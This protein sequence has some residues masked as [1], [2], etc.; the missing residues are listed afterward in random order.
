VL[1]ESDDDVVFA[2]RGSLNDDE[3]Y[4]LVVS[5]GGTP[6]R[7]WWD[8]IH[9]HSLGWVVARTGD[10]E[11]VGF[12]NVAWDGGDHAFLIDTKTRGSFQRHGIGTRLVQ[13]AAEHVKASGCDWLHV[14]FEPHLR[15]FYFTACGFRPTDAG[16]IDLRLT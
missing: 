3:L 5:H 12:V 2:W 9:P 8:R 4:D 6:E 1:D 13:L 14:D 15:P 11:L 7:G 10:G 16:L